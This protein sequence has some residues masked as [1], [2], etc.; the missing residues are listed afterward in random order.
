MHRISEKKGEKATET[1]ADLLLDLDI[2]EKRNEQTTCFTKTGPSHGHGNFSIGLRKTVGKYIRQRTTKLTIRLVRPARNQNS[3]CIRVVWSKSS[4]IACSFYSLQLS[5][6]G[7]TGPF[8]ILGGYMCRLIWVFVGLIVGFVVCWLNYMIKRL[9][10]D[11]FHIIPHI[12]PC[13]ISHHEN[14][15]I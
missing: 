11:I 10:Y 2:I 12:N 3:L 15:P 13:L 14:M 1:I 6:E 8:A 7:W 5:K 4:L 9:W